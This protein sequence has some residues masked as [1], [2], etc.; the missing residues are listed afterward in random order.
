LQD[1]VDICSQKDKIAEC[2]LDW[3]KCEQA[4]KDEIFA[5]LFSPFTNKL[6]NL[7]TDD[8]ETDI[9]K[10]KGF[11]DS[12]LLLLGVNLKEER[13][14]IIADMENHLNNSE[15]FT[16]EMDNGKYKV[17]ALNAAAFLRN[18]ED[19]E[20]IAY[21]MGQEY[22]DEDLKVQPAD[23]ARVLT[24]TQKRQITHEQESFF[25][26]LEKTYS[27]SYIPERRLEEVAPAAYLGMAYEINEDAGLDLRI[28]AQDSGLNVA[29]LEESMTTLPNIPEPV[30]V[31]ISNPG[32][33]TSGGGDSG[34]N[35]G[36]NGAGD[37][38]VTGTGNDDK[39]SVDV[40]KMGL[41]V[42]SVLIM[43]WK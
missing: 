33:D 7:N 2:F 24:A 40:W 30:V 11:L 32:G 39:I 13:K 27:K 12:Q 26:N 6:N 14:V 31:S 29:N 28:W 22:L 34:G 17:T 5:K 43:V 8:Y 18:L 35:G 25:R 37:G 20:K 41:V 21:F 38:N 42:W 10:T 4:F 23:P 16:F 36:N 9:D 3:T 15:P 1:K 19:T